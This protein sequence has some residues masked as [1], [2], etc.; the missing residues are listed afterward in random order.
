ML[1]S[2]IGYNKKLL[3]GFAL[4]FSLAG[5]ILIKTF[6]A[7]TQTASVEAEKMALPSGIATVFNDNKASGGQGIDFLQNGAVS[8]SLPLNGSTNNLQFVARSTKCKGGWPTL[9]VSV[10]SAKLYS[11]NVPSTKWKTFSYALP[12][13]IASGTHQ[14]SITASDV[15]SVKGCSR[16]VYLDKIDFYGDGNQPTPVPT[17]SITASPLAVSSGSSSTLNWSSTGAI[18]CSASGGW[19]GSK[20]V[21]GSASTGGLTATTTYNL[22][23]TGDG[24]TASASVTVTVSAVQVPP[25]P[26]I[27]LN[28]LTKSYAVGATFTVELREDSGS[29][30][31][32]AIQANLTY[33]TDK[34]E[35]VSIDAT[36]S[37]F[38]TQAQNDGGNG[39][40]AIA[41]GSTTAQSGNQLIAKI[42]FKAKTA[43]GSVTV[44]FVSGT[45]MVSSA[46]NRN[47]LSSLSSTGGGSYTIQ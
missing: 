29:Q 4:L 17:V 11:T 40:I 10:D 34:L 42:T 16:T 14:L 24:G 37:G 6:A 1:K 13:N 47:I 46:T 27:Y 2:K 19:S 21:S 15:G 39:Q 41:R 32:N 8:A 9:S 12:S 45:Q 33:P 38:S 26:T 7:T 28:P 25:A 43:T 31:V 44:P 23:C 20:A 18:S 30:Q 3:L 35:F 36:G 5:L 22:S